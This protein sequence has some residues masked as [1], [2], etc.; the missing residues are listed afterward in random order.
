MVDSYMRAHYTLWTNF[1]ARNKHLLPFIQVLVFPPVFECIVFLFFLLSLFFFFIPCSRSFF[2]I[3]VL[4][5]YLV[6]V[7][8]CY[9]CSCCCRWCRCLCVHSTRKTNKV[10]FYLHCTTSIWTFSRCWLCRSCSMVNVPTLVCSFVRFFFFFLFFKRNI[11]C[12]CSLCARLPCAPVVKCV[13]TVYAVFSFIFRRTSSSSSLL[14]YLYLCL[15][16]CQTLAFWSHLT[17]IS[18]VFLSRVFLTLPLPPSLSLS[19]SLP[20]PPSLS[21]SL[22]CVVVALKHWTVSLCQTCV[23]PGE[24]EI[25]LWLHCRCHQPFQVDCFAIFHR[26]RMM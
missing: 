10:M 8:C 4:F 19:P 15:F 7:C 13:C 26:P 18:L 20:P 22:A 25:I 12:F 6:L 3:W 5:W 1:V 23:Q 9:W 24:R 16:R 11:F 2:L 14:S 21:L 17:L